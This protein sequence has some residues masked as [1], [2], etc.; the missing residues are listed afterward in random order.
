MYAFRAI[1]NG[2]PLVRAAASGISGAFDSWDRMLGLA[3]WFAPGDRKLVVQVPVGG[4][5][6]VYARTGDLF[7]WLCVT[8]L[9]VALAIAAI[10]SRKVPAV[11]FDKQPVHHVEF[12]VWCGQRS[13]NIFGIM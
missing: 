9:I 7:A 8:G 2:V 1:E 13:S 4:V 6:T 12:P 10:A 11:T 5:R 3:D